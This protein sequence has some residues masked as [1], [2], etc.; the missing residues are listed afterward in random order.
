M[1]KISLSSN[2]LAQ[3]AH[4]GWGALLVLGLHDHLWHLSIATATGCVIS[5]ATLKEAVFDPL[6]EDP[7]TRGSGWV[8]FAFWCIGAA[9]GFVIASF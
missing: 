7:A 6:A 4:I 9:L 5:F 1:L 2:A 3:I 8:D